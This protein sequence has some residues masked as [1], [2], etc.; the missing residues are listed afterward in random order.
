MKNKN[1]SLATLLCIAVVAAGLI[2]LSLLGIGKDHLFGVQG[3]KQGLDLQ[4]GVSITYEASKDNPSSAEMSSASSLIRGRLDRKGYTEATLAQVGGNRFQVDIPGVEDAEQAINE[5]GRTALVTFCAPDGTVIFD[6]SHIKN[7]QREGYQKDSVVSYVVALEFDD[8]AAGL[9][10]EA[11]AAYINDV[12]II[13][14]DEDTISSP[15]VSSVISDGKCVIE[16]TFTPQEAEELAALIRAGSLP[17]SLDVITMNN[18]GA[19]LG[20]NALWSSI[21]AG[22][23]GIAIVFAF[24]A[25]IYKSAG[26]AADLA[27]LIYVGLMLVILSAFN[28]TLTLPGIAGIVLSIGMAVDANIIIFERLKEELVDN[29]RS[30]RSALDLAFKRAFTAILDG[31]I[32]TLISA[33]VLYWLGTGSV[34]GFAVTLSIGIVLSMFTAI[35]VTRIILK[36]FQGLG[37][38]NPKQY[39]VVR[40][41]AGK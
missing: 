3:I 22:V 20:E 30:F 15:K 2:V 40:E 26:L 31:N 32:T 18:V 34:K 16:G 21:W 19:Q 41:E 9:F 7:A 14:L 4:G 24:M 8:Y 27:L 23:A 39:G 28:L 13:K 5:I 10:A 36:C 17:F 33:L 11:T 25:F 12:I 6:G 35:V 1:Q 29:K 37:I 38:N